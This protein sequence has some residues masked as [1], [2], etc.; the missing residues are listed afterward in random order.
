MG[1]VFDDARFADVRD[2][3]PES[4]CTLVAVLGLMDAREVIRSLGGTSVAIPKCRTRAG[5]ASYAHL[6]ERVGDAVADRLIRH[7]GG[8]ILYVPRCD[9][10]LTE[11]TYRSIRRDFD[12]ATRPGGQSSVQVV[13]D[14][15]LRYGY[16]D[17]R[18]WAIL[19][20]PD[21]THARRKT[22]TRQLALFG[23]RALCA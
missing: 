4:A 7:F 12:W 21:K 8:G 19:K 2:L 16:S 22:D 14:L 17:R 5:Q 15:A 9:L 20:R 1:T 10:A 3:L 18:I 11:A 23:Q 6:A 13:G